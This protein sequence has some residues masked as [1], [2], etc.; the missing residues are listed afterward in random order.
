MSDRSDSFKLFVKA[1][2]FLISYVRDKK[3]LGRNYMNYMI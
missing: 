2:P 1:N 3:R